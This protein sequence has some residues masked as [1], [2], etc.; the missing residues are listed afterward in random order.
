MPQFNT[1]DEADI[2]VAASS[3]QVGARVKH[4]TRLIAEGRVIEVDLRLALPQVWVEW[5]NVE[6]KEFNPPLPHSPLDLVKLLVIEI[7]EGLTEDEEAERRW[8]EIKVEKAFYEAGMALKELRDRKLYR[9]THKSFEEYC[10]DRFGFNR[11]HPY[12]LIDAAVVVDNLSKKC[13]QIGDILPASESQC[14]PLVPLEPDI[15]VKIWQQAVE[16]VGSKKSPPAQVVKDAVQAFLGNLPLHKVNSSHKPNDIVLIRCGRGALPEQKR[17]KNYW[18]V[19]EEVREY[20]VT[21]SVGGTTVAYRADDLE[22]IDW[23]EAKMRQVAD[24]VTRLLAR[25]DLELR[26]RDIL[27]GFQR[28]HQFSDWDMRLLKTISEWREQDSSCQSNT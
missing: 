8:L 17:Y 26:E 16:K 7:I 18:G 9:N 1:T 24:L 4:R 28:H 2:F 13:L 5:D 11:A 23:E 12:R 15:Q 20:S 22:P 25:K 21:V 6:D 14:R 10:R 19:V 27:R 3:F